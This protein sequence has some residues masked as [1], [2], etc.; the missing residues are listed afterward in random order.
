[1]R[2]ALMTRYSG[3]NAARAAMDGGAGP[4][5]TVVDDMAA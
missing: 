3:L 5:V 1:M 4:G 2:A